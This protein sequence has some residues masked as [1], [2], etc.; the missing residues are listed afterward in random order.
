MDADL[1]ELI[2]WLDFTTEESYLLETEGFNDFEEF[3][4]TT[5]DELKFM[6]DGFYKRNDLAFTIPIKRHKFLYDI[7][8]WCGDFDCRNMEAGINWPGDEIT[9]G[10]CA[11]SAM[12]LARERAL[13][14]ND[15]THTGTAP[16]TVIYLEE[17]TIF[18][19]KYEHEHFQLL[20]RE[21]MES[22]KNAWSRHSSA[23]T[24]GGKSKIDAT[25]RKSEVTFKN[26]KKELKET[27]RILLALQVPTAPTIADA[28]KGSP[29]PAVNSAETEMTLYAE[30]TQKCGR[31]SRHE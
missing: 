12:S 11:F 26:M 25:K 15:T 22:L 21:E 13:V 8:E 2:G 7:L 18:I 10:N 30:V 4:S 5:K 24:K 28:Q 23:K 6:I 27:H 3:D 9:N 14:H 16:S 17:G 29:A 31:D 1:K 20:Y 19:E